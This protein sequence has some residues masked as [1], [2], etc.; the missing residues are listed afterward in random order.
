MCPLSG[1]SCCSPSPFI[2]H[3]LSARSAS[4][5]FADVSFEALSAI[6]AATGGEQTWISGK[7]GFSA[8]LLHCQYPW[9]KGTF[10]A[11]PF[12][13]SLK[14]GLLVGPL[15]CPVGMLEGKTISPTWP[16]PRLPAAGGPPA[17]RGRQKKKRTHRRRRF[18]TLS[19]Q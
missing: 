5:K 19:T 7:K 4:L 2:P 1:N 15:S 9:P 8:F 17:A 18:P 16:R 14:R 12:V 3:P 13:R 10:G 6:A 11:G